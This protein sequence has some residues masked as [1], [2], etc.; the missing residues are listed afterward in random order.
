MDAQKA[1]EFTPQS[2]EQRPVVTAEYNRFRGRGTSKQDPDTHQ[3]VTSTDGRQP[4]SPKEPTDVSSSRGRASSSSGTGDKTDA[5]GV[6]KTGTDGDTTASPTVTSEW[7]RQATPTQRSPLPSV[8]STEMFAA[9]VAETTQS[10]R[11]E[12]VAAWSATI[13][14]LFA[15]V[16]HAVPVQSE[17]VPAERKRF[18]TLHA[19]EAS[20]LLGLFEQACATRRSSFTEWEKIAKLIAKELITTKW[21]FTDIVRRIASKQKWA[22]SPVL[23]QWATVVRTGTAASGPDTPRKNA[24]LPRYEEFMFDPS[25]FSEEDISR[26]RA[27]CAATGARAR[28]HHVMEGTDDEWKVIAGLVEGNVACRRLPDFVKE[29][30]KSEERLRLLRTI[31]AQVEGELVLHLDRARGNRVSR[32]TTKAI[33]ESILESAKLA[34]AMLQALHRMLSQTK[35]ICYDQVTKTIHFYFFTR[36]TSHSHREV[37]V[38]FYG[39]V[40]RLHNAHRPEKGSIWQRQLGH[41]GSPTGR[42]AEYAVHL[43]NLTRFSDV[44]KIAAFVKTKIP[45]DFD[46]DDMDTHTPN[47]RTST[48]WRVTFKLAICPTFLNGACL[49]RG[50]LDHTLVLCSFTDVQLRGPG[51]IVVSQEDV[52]GLDDLAIHFSSLAELKAMAGKRLQLQKG[53]YQTAQMAVTPSTPTEAVQP[54]TEGSQLFPSAPDISSAPQVEKGTFLSIYSLS[55]NRSHSNRG[56][57]AQARAVA[58]HLQAP[59]SIPHASTRSTGNYQSYRRTECSRRRIRPT[60]RRAKNLN[61]VLTWST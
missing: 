19:A 52:R 32:R 14:H 58:T 16:N 17:E 29:V 55:R 30:L 38:P 20:A 15:E 28:L 21:A 56:F 42:R 18:P 11:T 35:T 59:K 34:R 45:T 33:T 54:G 60:N 25:A 7:S 24:E 39:G 23:S 8:T 9:L 1:T 47:S 46:M 26:L 10:P 2:A 37:M 41:N 48:I 40:N 53:A 6:G 57:P 27:L 13:Q 43:H 49:Q 44:D 12:H 61:R 3:E 4:E 36:T 50:N 51:A 5:S 22:Y 31:Q